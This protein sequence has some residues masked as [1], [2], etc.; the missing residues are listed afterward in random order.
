M[1]GYRY[2]IGD[3]LTINEQHKKAGVD[4]YT[5][6]VY[7]VV[8]FVPRGSMKNGKEVI[9]DLIKTVTIDGVEFIAHESKFVLNT[10]RGRDEK[11]EKLGI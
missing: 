6:N 2:K 4:W 10:Q 7:Y 11:L 5:D 3:A 1:I 9:H 8:G